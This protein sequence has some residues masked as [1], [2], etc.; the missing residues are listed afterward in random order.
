MK[1]IIS[2]R[3]ESKSVTVSDLEFWSSEDPCC[4][5]WSSPSVHSFASSE[6]ALWWLADPYSWDHSLLLPLALGLSNTLNSNFWNHYQVI[7]TSQKPNSSVCWFFKPSCR[8]V[9][10]GRPEK[11][12]CSIE[13]QAA[14]ILSSFVTFFVG[15]LILFIF[16]LIWRTIKKWQNIKGIGIILVSFLIWDRTVRRSRQVWQVIVFRKQF[17]L[18]S[19]FMS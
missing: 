16:R 5:P 4:G 18:H 9:E 15:L 2:S 7:V 6:S 3:S 19:A 13:I 10:W 8:V 17:K 11:M 1:A 12:A 14:F